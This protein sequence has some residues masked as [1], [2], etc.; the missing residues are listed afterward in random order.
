MTDPTEQPARP[1]DVDTAILLWL[2]AL[3]LMTGAYVLDL[4]VT[5]DHPNSLILALSLVFAGILVAVVLTFMYLLRLGYRW[6]RTLLTGGGIAS[7]VYSL[8]NLS[9][10]Q[11]PETAAMAYA[12]AV[13]VGSVLIVGG[14]YLL[15]RKDSHEFFTS[16]SLG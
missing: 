6:A 2:V 9:D 10:G 11:R 12:A 13:I 4:L 3:P 16:G 1:E 7:V 15:H 5:R 8:S 14:A